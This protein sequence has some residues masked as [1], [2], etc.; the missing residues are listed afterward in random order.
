M[1][2][3]FVWIGSKRAEKRG[4]GAPG[5]QL[6]YAA[7]MGLPV[8]AGAILLH[9]FY[10][11]L[12][13]EGL[14]HWQNGRFHAHNAHEIYDALYT[15][16]RF[17]HLDKPAVIRPTFTPAAAAVLQLQTNIDMQNPQQ[18]TDALCAVWSVGAAP[19]TQ[20]RRDVLIQEMLD[21][22]WSGTLAARPEPAPDQVHYT[23]TN[24]GEQTLALP[25]LRR[26]QAANAHLP[27]FAQRL[28]MLM[29]GVRR[30]F[31]DDVQEIGWV[32][33]GRVCWLD[34]ISLT[35]DT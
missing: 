6:D 5:A 14:I 27:P 12:V 10:Q 17:P 25:R 34:Y 28:Q 15:A 20:I 35:P 24:N 2:T 18:L 23:A 33:N 9:E 31:G 7:R 30:T 13:D 1:K 16:V 32:D 26:W 8:A 22:H 19:T 11:L 4:V 29:R 3:P 21:A